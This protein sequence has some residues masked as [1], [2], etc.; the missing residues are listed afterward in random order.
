MGRGSHAGICLLLTT[1]PLQSTAWERVAAVA[2]TT[3]GFALAEIDLEQRREGDILGT[4]QS[5]GKS[6]LKLLRVTRD[7]EVIAAARNAAEALLGGDPHL[8]KHA[9]LRQWISERQPELTALAKS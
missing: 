5:G 8:A 7:G 4:A 1:A 2:E 3:D 6:T 9:A